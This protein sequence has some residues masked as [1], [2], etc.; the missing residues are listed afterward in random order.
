MRISF[1]C[2]PLSSVCAPEQGSDPECVPCKARGEARLHS[3]EGQ[4]VEDQNDLELQEVGLRVGAEWEEPQKQCARVGWEAGKQTAVGEP[5]KQCPR[6][7]WEAGKR[8]RC[9]E[10]A[11]D[12]ETCCVG[13][14][15]VPRPWVL[16]RS[17]LDFGGKTGLIHYF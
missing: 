2:V 8:P 4:T 7:G 12:K 3:S 10:L 13:N 16:E 6:V 11:G 9:P 15:C 17:L 5:Q 14:G 1:Y